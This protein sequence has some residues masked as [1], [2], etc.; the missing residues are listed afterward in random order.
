MKVNNNI[1]ERV[2]IYWVF[3]G[4]NRFYE[5]DTIKN[6]FILKAAVE[7]IYNHYKYNQLFGNN[8]M[9]LVKSMDI[10]KD[11]IPILIIHK[12]D[13]PKYVSHH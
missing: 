12:N 2:K 3:C 6:S 7:N 13:F 9:I 5:E 1:Y 10:V 4:K 8:K 11:E